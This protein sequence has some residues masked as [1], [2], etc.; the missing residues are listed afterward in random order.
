MLLELVQEATISAKIFTIVLMALLSLQSC[1][2]RELNN[3]T[4]L[5]SDR[6]R[7]MSRNSNRRLTRRFYHFV[8]VIENHPFPRRSLSAL[9][10]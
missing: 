2:V 6:Y 10:H 7:V 8:V 9:K 1:I 5:T 3:C 4:L